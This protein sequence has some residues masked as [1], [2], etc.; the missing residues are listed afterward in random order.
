MPHK[1]R[2]LSIGD[3]D[4]EYGNELIKGILSPKLKSISKYESEPES[5]L[6]REYSPL[7]LTSEIIKPVEIKYIS[8]RMLPKGMSYV[9]YLDN[10]YILVN[11]DII[12]SELLEKYAVK[13][14]IKN[15]LGFIDID[16]CKKNLLIKRHNRD[17]MVKYT[18]GCYHLFSIDDV[19]NYNI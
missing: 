1:I 10:S 7:I 11:F 19:L 8:S 15:Y 16:K 12:D 17:S 6:D 5:K 13:L 3:S 18:M 4:D 14:R 9:K 2:L